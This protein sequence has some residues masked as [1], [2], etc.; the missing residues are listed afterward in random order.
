MTIKYS[1]IIPTRNKAEY[2]P[3]AIK[4]VLDSSRDDIEVIVS[5]NFSTDNTSEIL[6][7]I[8]D[9]RL[10]VIRPNLT[11]PMAGHYEFA[12]S[13]AKGEWITIL[14]DDDAVMPYIFESLDNYIKR[15]SEIDI[16]SS[17]RS[18]Y[19]WKDSGG[20]NENK[21]V[22]YKSST[23]TKIRSTKK[24]LIN[25]LQGLRNCFDMPQIYTT[26]IV[27]RTLYNEIKINSGGF[28]YHSIIPDMYS[29][30]ALC[31]SRKKYLRVEEPL[32][33]VGT[34][35][36]SMGRATRIYEDAQNFVYDANGKYDYVKKKISKKAS[37]ILHSN[38]FSP[39][40]IFECLLQCPLKNNFYNQKKI[41][42]LV[43]AAVLNISRKKQ[44]KDLLKKEI[45][46]E[47]AKNNISKFKLYFT[48]WILNIKFITLLLIRLPYLVLRE[49]GLTKSIIL[50]SNNIQKFPTILDASESIKTLRKN[51][52]TR[53]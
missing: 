39:Y 28:F 21:V 29:V 14:G 26:C 25:V 12:I 51:F 6:S 5:N 52:E 45:H 30:V 40:Y 19:F 16:I 44:N 50:R 38:Q 34:S 35:K 47:S 32:F 4:S 11:L 9:P 46:L 33:W 13:H 7:K 8:T 22:I 41:K 37:Y 53:K 27:K 20:V 23:K 36:K 24:D 18:Y 42:T 49:C 2:L 48:A 17:S 43:L 1:I 31:L 3:Y 15:H 10:K